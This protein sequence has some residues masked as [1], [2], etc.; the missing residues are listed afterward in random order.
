MASPETSAVTRLLR[1]WQSGRKE[2]LD[3]LMP[4]VYDKLRALA[5][6][7]MRSENPG[8]TLRATA[9]VHEAYMRLVGSDISFEDRSHF[10]A[11]SARMMRRILIDH[12]KG[13]LR[14]KRGGGAAKVELDE[15]SAIA[16]DQPEMLLAIHEALER[17]AAL[18]PRKAEILELIYFGGMEQDM[19]AAA[20]KISPATLR[21]DLRLAKAWM[22]NELRPASQP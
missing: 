11:I 15:N 1:E 21:R 12:A 17:L 6:G 13:H 4:L 19:A 14:G 16:L 20:L 10:Y 8:H 9:L 7:Y 3:E 18:D 5:D 2:A 22:Y